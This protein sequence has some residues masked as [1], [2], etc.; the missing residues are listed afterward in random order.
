MSPW[1]LT[2]EWTQVQLPSQK[3]LMQHDLSRSWSIRPE[4]TLLL[5]ALT[6]RGDNE[7]GL[8]GFDRNVL[9]D[10]TQS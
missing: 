2:L 7:V 8:N 3:V 4:D 5:L 10:V 6:K 9:V 1:F